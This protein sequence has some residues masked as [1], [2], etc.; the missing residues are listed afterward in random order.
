VALSVEIG[1]D[2]IARNINVVRGLGLGLDE[3]AITAIQ[4]W[5]FQPGTKDGAPV[6][7]VAS[8]EVNFRLQ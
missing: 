5:H 6:P 7:V 8:I 4:Q 1:P 3:N 2:G